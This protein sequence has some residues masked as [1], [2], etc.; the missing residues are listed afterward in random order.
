MNV[1][2]ARFDSPRSALAAILEVSIDLE[3]GQDVCGAC[4]YVYWGSLGECPN[5]ATQQRREDF[6]KGLA[7]M[8][9][10]TPES[11]ESA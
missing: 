8:S 6:M 2:E 7:H 5:C 4:Q 1:P 3:D 10:N 11:K 9:V